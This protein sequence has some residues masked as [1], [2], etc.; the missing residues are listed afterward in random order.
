MLIQL[1]LAREAQLAHAARAPSRPGVCIAARSFFAVIR[2]SSCGCAAA[3]ALIPV[4]IVGFE[5]LLPLG[6]SDK[7]LRA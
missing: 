6:R 4:G 2:R 1:R 5:A 7:C 3:A